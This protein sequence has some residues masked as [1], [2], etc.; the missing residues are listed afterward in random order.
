MSWLFDR[1]CEI[2]VA[3][4]VQVVV[5]ARHEPG[6]R[7][8]LVDVL[9]RLALVPDAEITVLPAGHPPCTALGP[10][11]QQVELT[12]P[13]GADRAPTGASA[14]VGRLLRD[15]TERGLALQLQG[16][17]AALRT[18]A[19]AHGH[20]RELGDGRAALVVATDRPGTGE[21]LRLA[22]RRGLG[23]AV[24]GVDPQAA[25]VMDGFLGVVSIL[26]ALATLRGFA[27]GGD[28]HRDELVRRIA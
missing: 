10:S 17:R 18:T 14:V 4:Q 22:S 21:L 6:E 27:C 7:D 5:A 15:A 20:A 11:M 25:V 19:D 13:V 16:A 1:L 26:D 3:D 24:G 23:I 12:G 28:H 2:A 8:D 9:T